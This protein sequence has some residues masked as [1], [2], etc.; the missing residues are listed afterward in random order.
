M[1]VIIAHWLEELEQFNMEL[2]HR[3]GN[4]Q[5]NADAMSRLPED[6]LAPDGY[7]AGA[8]PESVSCGWC[9]YCIRVHINLGCWWCFTPITEVHS[10][11]QL[12]YKNIGDAFNSFTTKLQDSHNPLVFWAE[13][14]PLRTLHS[15]SGRIQTLA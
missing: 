10:N 12:S 7:V 6:E 13:G 3:S 1:N 11:R 9:C 4:K 15:C 5:S 2:L 14:I 8:T